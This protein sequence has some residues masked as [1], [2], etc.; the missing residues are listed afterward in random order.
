ME[1]NN[2]DRLNLEL[3]RT[4]AVAARAPTFAAASRIRGVTVSAISQQVKTLEA[5]LGLALFERRGRRVTLTSAGLAL[6]NELET[7]LGQLALALERATNA[8]S[9]VE[10]LVTLGGPRTFGGFYVLPRL[11]KLLRERP[12]LRVDQRFEVPSVLERQLVDGAL[13]LAV[14]SRPPEAAGLETTVLTTETFVAVAAPALLRRLPAARTE[15]ALREWP[16]LAFDSDLAMH[17][18]WWR[19]SFGRA[20]TPPRRL[21]AAVASLEHLQ[22]FAEAALGAVVLPDYLVGPAL[23]ARRLVRVYPSAP[24]RAA[25]E[26]TNTLFLVSRR[27]APPTARLLAVREALRSPA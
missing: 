20:A 3:L 11:T 15:A 16:W 6:S 8:H 12:G 7:H 5:Q 4:F 13:D 14:L 18:P 2:I 17:A 24:G 1:L 25:R 9:K 21:V 27:G 19:A 26:A 22:A 23:S 10:G